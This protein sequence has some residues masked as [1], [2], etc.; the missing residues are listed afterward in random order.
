MPRRKGRRP[1]GSLRQ[2]PSGRWQARYRD[3]AGNPHT[4]PQ[5]F[6]TR[7][8]ATRFLAQ[9]ETDLARGRRDR[10]TGR[11]GVVR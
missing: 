11:S 3:A 4:A 8:Q 6:G 5:T 10:P 9:V 1:F 2:L 7:P